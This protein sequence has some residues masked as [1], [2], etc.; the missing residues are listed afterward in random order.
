[1]ELR[2]GATSAGISLS[3]LATQVR[4]AVYGLDS[5]VFASGDEE[6]YI[7]VKLGSDVRTNIG[8]LEQLWITTAMGT[9]I[10]LVEI[11]H[12]S[13][14]RGYTTIRRIDRKRTATIAAEVV[15][16]ASPDAISTHLP[17]VDEESTFP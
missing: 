8:V 6:V 16:G 3:E 4:G 2:D 12:I 7:R 5:H 14:K 1:M 15:D 13:E 17:Y 10:P 11:A 9:S